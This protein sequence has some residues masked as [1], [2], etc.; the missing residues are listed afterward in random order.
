MLE[1]FQFV[2]QHFIFL[3]DFLL[4][5]KLPVMFSLQ[6]L[7]SL[8]QLGYLHFLLSDGLKMVGFSYKYFVRVVDYLP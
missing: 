7:N 6:L 5:Q 2:L 1:L 3:F 8:S 4:T